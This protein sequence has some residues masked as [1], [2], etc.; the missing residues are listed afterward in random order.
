MVVD[1]K[2]RRIKN[3]KKRKRFS[4]SPYLREVFC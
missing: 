4:I 1:E 3:S 2:E